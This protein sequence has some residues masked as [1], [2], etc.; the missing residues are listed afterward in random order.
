[1]VKMIAANRVQSEASSFVGDLMLARTEAIKRGQAVSLC[2]STDGATCI[3]PLANTWNVGWITFPDT[4][5][6]QCGTPPST[7]TVLRKRAGFVGGD[8]FVAAPS[9]TCL[10]F[11]RE[12]LAVN[13]GTAAVYFKLH[14]P[15]NASNSTRCV[16]VNLGGRV[17]TQT[18]KT[19]TS[20]T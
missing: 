13:L 8:T 15:D 5:T 3:S 18:T 7:P 4:S 14:T 16:L 1:M 20:C 11:N 10:G 6:T 17:T 9:V 2:P 12:G 19:D